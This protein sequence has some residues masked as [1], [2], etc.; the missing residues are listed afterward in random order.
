MYICILTK[1]NLV[2]TKGDGAGAGWGGGGAKKPT[3]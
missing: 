1:P 3:F 2:A